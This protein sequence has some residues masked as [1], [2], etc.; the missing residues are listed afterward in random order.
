MFDYKLS[1]HTLADKGFELRFSP[2]VRIILGVFALVLLLLIFIFNGASFV[3]Y[4]LFTLAGL[5]LMF[6]DRWIWHYKG[7]YL[8]HRFGLIFWYKKRIFTKPSIEQ[9]VLKRFFRGPRTEP[10][11]DKSP[12]TRLWISL[13]ID[14]TEHGSLTVE[15]HKEGYQDDLHTFGLE[16]ARVLGLTLKEEQE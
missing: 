1:F 14:S 4:V 12:F 15:T 9:V 8:E 7:S 2:L 6:E 13:A 3:G 5:S 10:G 11:K 16:L